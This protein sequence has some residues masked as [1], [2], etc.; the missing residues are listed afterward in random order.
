MF[1]E[2]T[3]TV[4]LPLMARRT[5]EALVQVLRLWAIVLPTNLAGALLFAWVAGNTGA[6]A[7]GVREA[8]AAIGRDSMAADGGTVLLR[9]IFS[10]WLIALMVWLLPVAQTARVPVIIITYLVGLAGFNHIAAGSVETLYLVCTGSVPFIPW[11]GGFALPTLVGNV[12]VGVTLISVLNHA[13]AM[14]RES[15]TEAG[16]GRERGIRRQCGSGED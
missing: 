12:L 7:P 16:S 2:N 6:F 13:Q 5:V 11:L 8:F 3:L 4:I 15:S 10:G 14:P 1:T 9:S